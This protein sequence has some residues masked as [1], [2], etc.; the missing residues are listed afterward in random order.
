MRF[1]FIT[2]S[3]FGRAHITIG[4]VCLQAGIPNFEEIK[5]GLSHFHK[6]NV[7]PRLAYEHAKQRQAGAPLHAIRTIVRWTSHRVRMG[8]RFIWRDELCSWISVLRMLLS[9]VTSYAF[10]RLG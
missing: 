2:S 7:P 10:R 9:T 1:V 3:C 4:L 8:S 6:N 5:T